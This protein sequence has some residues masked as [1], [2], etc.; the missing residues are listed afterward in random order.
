MI[1]E[2]DKIL[3]ELFFPHVRIYDSEILKDERQFLYYME[4][5]GAVHS[6]RETIFLCD[7]DRDFTIFYWELNPQPSHKNKRVILQEDNIYT[8][9][10]WRAVEELRSVEE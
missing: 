1:S 8:E 3:R 2:E 9:E 6:G 10:L 4:K 7:N 5:I